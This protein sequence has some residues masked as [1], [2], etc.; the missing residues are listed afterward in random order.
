MKVSVVVI[1]YN[2]WNYLTNCLPSL[3]FLTERTDV[4]VI[5]VDNGSSDGS[6][7]KVR[8]LF[9]WIKLIE[10]SRNEGV[11]VARNIGMKQAQGEYILLLDSDA[12]MNLA[13]FD[14]LLAFMDEHPEVG[15]CGCKMFGQDGT[16]QDSCRPFPTISGKV[17]AGIHIIAKKF[18]LTTKSASEY[19]DKEVAEPFSVDYVIGACQLIRH[20]VVKQIGGLDEKIFYGPEDADFCLRMHRAGYQVYYLPQTAIYHAYQRESSH[21]IFSELTKKHV[22][23]LLYYFWKH[24]AKRT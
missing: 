14:I 10:N 5:Y 12:E 1:G 7:G 22:Q 11:A 16:V 20:A 19:Y 15:L 18:R 2:S 9:P 4:E 21:R 3:S 8:E 13:T 24:R 6:Q 17:K 23:G